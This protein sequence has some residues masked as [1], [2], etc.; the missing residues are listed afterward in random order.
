MGRSSRRPPKEQSQL[1]NKFISGLSEKERKIFYITAIVVCLALL[2]RLF[3]NPVMG[4]L[5]T[6]D[7]KIEEEKMA[8]MRDR[9]ILSYESK[10]N[11]DSEVFKKYF[12]EAV[13]NDNE[14]NN[15]FF[16]LIERLASQTNVSLVKNNPSHINKGEQLNEYFASV[17]A[18]GR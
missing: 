4:H 1:L 5:K 16:G 14:V 11:K 9:R 15:E 3:L 2:D 13:P 17:D 7:R 6:L 10:I 8:I 12:T 18:N